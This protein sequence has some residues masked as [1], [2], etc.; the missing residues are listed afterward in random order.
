MIDEAHEAFE[1]DEYGEKIAKTFALVQKRGPAFGVT[2]IVLTQLPQA[3]SVP[4]KVRNA[5]VGRVALKLMYPEDSRA[6]LGASAGR[7][8]F[9]ASDL[10]YEPGRT[11][12]RAILQGAGPNPLWIRVLSMTADQAEELVQVALELRREA[13]VLPGQD[14]PPP[15]AV[16]LE[17]HRIL[18]SRGGVVLSREV[19]EHLAR[20][21]LIRAPEGQ[22]DANALPRALARHLRP[23]RIATVRDEQ[24]RLATYRVEDVQRALNGQS[25]TVG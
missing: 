15:D 8:G 4:T 6:A 10:P 23:W 24:T 7:A 11:E 25:V 20:L 16:V 5:I 17:L 12:G 18:T 13:G 9:D 21:E 19:A 2:F 3:E 14:T 22:D 1:D